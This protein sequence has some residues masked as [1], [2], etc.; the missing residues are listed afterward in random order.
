MKIKMTGI[1]LTII[2]ILVLLLSLDSNTGTSISTKPKGDH[3]C[4]VTYEAKDNYSNNIIALSCLDKKVI[5]SDE[6]FK[7]SYGGGGDIEDSLSFQAH[8]IRLSM[9]LNT[10]KIKNEIAKTN[11]ILTNINAN[12]IKLLEK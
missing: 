10:R 11:E 3:T 6:N 2:A 1:T 7:T 9:D 12:L 8:S 4:Y 5:S